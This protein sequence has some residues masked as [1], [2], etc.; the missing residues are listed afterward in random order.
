[1][2]MQRT[3][4]VELGEIKVSDHK[5][6][7]Y[8][9]PN[10]GTGVAVTIYDIQN[11]V[12]GIAHIVL[13]E[14]SLD[15]VYSDQ[16]PGKYANLAIPKLLEQFTAIGGQKRSSIVRMVGGAQLFNFGGGG[17]NV[18]NIGARNATAIR[19]AMSKQGYAI[20]KADTG[21]NKGKSIRF[22]LATG[23][24]YV[25]QIGGNEYLL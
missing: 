17:G 21:G 3:E 23:Q 11:K 12:G 18:L 8:I 10:L 16:L 14:S 25:R 7:V 5:A 2:S 9:I 15:G 20:E 1:M 19:A 24:L 4:Q 13:P 6:T 22:I